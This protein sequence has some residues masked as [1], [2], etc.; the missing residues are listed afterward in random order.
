MEACRVWSVRVYLGANGGR[1]EKAGVAAENRIRWE[2]GDS[3]FL[4]VLVGEIQGTF[5]QTASEWSDGC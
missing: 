4:C 5:S 3:L 1:E 2:C